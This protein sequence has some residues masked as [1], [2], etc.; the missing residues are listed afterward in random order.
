MPTTIRLPICT[1]MYVSSSHVT[2]KS[3]FVR[4]VSGGVQPA[5]AMKNKPIVMASSSDEPMLT[6]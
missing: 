3:A 6:M 1:Q 2:A 5:P 4:H